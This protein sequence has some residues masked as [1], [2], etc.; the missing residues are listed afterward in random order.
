LS[1]RVEALQIGAEEFTGVGID[2]LDLG[3]VRSFV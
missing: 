2:V 3:G 1:V